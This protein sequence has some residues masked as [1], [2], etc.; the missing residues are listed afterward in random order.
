MIDFCV[1]ILTHGRPD[2]V[3]TFNTLRKQ[4]YTGPIYI[5]IDSEDRML[6]AYR[7]RFGDAVF[8]INKQKIAEQID[9]GDNF[10]DRRAI[11]YA[12]NACFTLANKIGIRYFVQLDDDYTDFRFKQNASFEPLNILRLIKNLDRSFASMI[13]FLKDTKAFAVAI[14]QNGDFLGGK[15]GKAMAKPR[16]RKCMN[17]FFCDAEKAFRFSGRINEDVNSYVSN[18]ARG[19][20][21]LTAPNIA[22][23]QRQSQGT[24]G[25]MTEIYLESGTYVK[26]FYTVM[27]NPSCVSITLMQSNHPR[28]HHRINWLT[29]VPVIVEEIHKKTYRGKS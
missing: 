26:S 9:E 8:I 15:D 2:K 20:L 27:Y 12:R 11:I 23:Q 24:K 1:F 16:Y 14:A 29:A 13:E 10:E 6:E 18:G 22:L 28:L 25:G 5:V 19:M 3:Y 7:I 4:G 21:F 17:S